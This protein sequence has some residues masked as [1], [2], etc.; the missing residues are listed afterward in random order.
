MEAAALAAHTK[1]PG[2]ACVSND[3]RLSTNT[4]LWLPEVETSSRLIQE[5]TQE[6]F[7]G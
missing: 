4:A 2:Q 3:S 7:G 6:V 1:A 5:T